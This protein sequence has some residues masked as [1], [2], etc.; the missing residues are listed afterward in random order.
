LLRPHLLGTAGPCLLLSQAEP[1]IRR[2]DPA[3]RVKVVASLFAVMVL[4]LSGILIIWLAG[5]A[6]R[7]YANRTAS[8]ARRRS[9]ARWREDDWADK[10]LAPDDEADQN[11]S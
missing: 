1:L 5:R 3:T 4:G 7:R 9:G 10:P 11:Q 6:A 8:P 2:L